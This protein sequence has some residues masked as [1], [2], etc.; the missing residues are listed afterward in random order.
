MERRMKNLNGGKFTNLLI[1]LHDG[2][3]PALNGWKYDKVSR[4]F[5]VVV[6]RVERIKIGV[7]QNLKQKTN[8]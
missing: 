8:S 3:R 2:L 4:T 6:E 7:L 1:N 5:I